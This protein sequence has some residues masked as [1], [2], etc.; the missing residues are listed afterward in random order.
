VRRLIGTAVTAT[1]LAVALLVGPLGA[2]ATA[3]F[4]YG[5]TPAARQIAGGSLTSTVTLYNGSAAT[6]NITMK[7]LAFD[8]TNVSTLMLPTVSVFSVPA[9]TTKIV[10][11]AN[12]ATVDPAVDNTI[13]STVRVVSDQ[14]IAVGIMLE[15]ATGPRAF[16]CMYLHP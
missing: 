1:A 12:P 16:P 2:S 7:L 3:P 15:L 11:W 5:C 6:A 9:T 13:P 14:A 10:V 8:G 4:V